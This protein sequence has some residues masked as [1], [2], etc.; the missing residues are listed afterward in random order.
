MVKPKETQILTQVKKAA[1]TAAI[2]ENKSDFSRDDEEIDDFSDD[3]FEEEKVEK[4][5]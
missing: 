3:D 2:Q 5:T 4:P 1:A